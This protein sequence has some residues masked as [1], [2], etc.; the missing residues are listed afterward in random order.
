MNAALSIGTKYGATQKA[1]GV[2]VVEPSFLPPPSYS[3]SWNLHGILNTLRIGNRADAEKNEFSVSAQHEPHGEFS[4]LAQN[5]YAVT[6]RES[7]RGYS[8]A[9]TII[10]GG[11]M[12]V[13]ASVVI[14][15]PVSVDRDAKNVELINAEKIDAFCRFHPEINS[16]LERS[17][18][19]ARKYFHSNK[20]TLE[21]ISDPD[22][23][24]GF[25]EIAMYIQVS[26]LDEE[27][28]G[29]LESVNR[30][31]FSSPSENSLILNISLD[32]A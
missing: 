15:P 24:S 18:K 4:V 14:T 1:G 13:G 22:S 16:Y 11:N 23:T 20:F 21:F 10:R 6:L 5:F 25:E 3:K 7:N 8:D 2:F 32:S 17:I 30:E 9:W 27:S 28:F 31:R 19:I 26:R 29:L 12:S